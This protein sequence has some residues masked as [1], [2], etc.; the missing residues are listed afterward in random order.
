MTDLT[1]DRA[2]EL[3]ESVPDALSS[4]SSDECAADL[5]GFAVSGA[6]RL[7][8]LLALVGLSPP[9]ALE[10]GVGLLE[11]VDEQVDP[12]GAAFATDRLMV[13]VDGRVVIEPGL[14]DGSLRTAGP[15]S[16][17]TARRAAA[18]LTEVAAASRGAAGRADPATAQLLDLLDDAVA[19]LPVAD[20]AAVLQQLD[21]ASAA[22]DRRAVR[23]E[24]AA[25]VRAVAERSGSGVLGGAARSAGATELC[26][27]KPPSTGPLP[28]VRTRVWMWLLSVAVLVAVVAL[29]V[30]LLRDDIVA[31]VH[32]LLEAGRSGSTASTVPEPD[33]LPLVPPAPP[34]IGTVAGV[35]LRPLTPC[36][37]GAPCTVRVMLRLLPATDPQTVSWS[38][39][40]ADRCTG[41]TD[42]AAGGSVTVPAGA[43]Q[44]AAVDTVLLPAHRAVAVVAVTEL[45]AAAA[46]PPVLIGSCAPDQTTR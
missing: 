4:A 14:P 27:G 35:D 5:S 8:R 3:T 43:Q 32:L 23:A 39:Q 12:A 44:V 16:D 33:G 18:A 10:I 11:A 25:L 1:I 46:A 41:A 19:E 26:P 22:I 6:V 7:T 45:P 17:T 36:T 40:L 31:D 34:A 24:L 20:V 38:F 2:T 21:E 9:Q 28:A 15:G 29:E 13:G 37:P 30:V 42:T